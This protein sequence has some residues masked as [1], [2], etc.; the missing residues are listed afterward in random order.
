MFVLQG[1]LLKDRDDPGQVL[2]VKVTFLFQRKPSFYSFGLGR[3]V[4]VLLFVGAGD[5]CIQYCRL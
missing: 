5:L 4:D 1:A 3:L 2:S